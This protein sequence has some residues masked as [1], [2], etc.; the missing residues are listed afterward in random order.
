MK[1]EWERRIDFRNSLSLTPEL[2]DVLSVR[3]GDFVVL[4]KIGEGVLE[5]RRRD[6]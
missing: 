6:K 2:L 1:K 5:I 4:S 3:A